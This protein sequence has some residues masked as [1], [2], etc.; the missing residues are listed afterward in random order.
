[1]KNKTILFLVAALSL[2]AA[3]AF[4]PV[5]RHPLQGVW[6]QT[7]QIQ[8]RDGA[9]KIVYIPNFKFLLEDGNFFNMMGYLDKAVSPIP[10][11]ITGS[12]S[13][14][15]T[16]DSTYVEHLVSS[17][18]EPSSMGKDVVLTYRL[19]EDGERLF[20]TFRMNN[21]FEGKEIWTRVRI[22]ETV[23]TAHS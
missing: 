8:D 5:E 20:L 1:M 10:A 21:G 23:S 22:M 2:A 9:S 12:G 19:S 13:W 11:H 16:S 14:E 17:P 15:A 7:L 18:T 6:Q 4:K 3:T